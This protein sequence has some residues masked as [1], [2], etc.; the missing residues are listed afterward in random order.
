MDILTE[1]GERNAA[2]EKLASLRKRRQSLLMK[3]EKLKNERVDLSTERPTDLN[4][5]VQKYSDI[6]HTYNLIGV[7]VQSVEPA[8][9]LQFYPLC[10]NQFPSTEFY[11]VH[12]IVKGDNFTLGKHNLPPFIPVERVLDTAKS[13]S[14]VIQQI[15][16]YLYAL[17]QRKG[18]LKLVQEKFESNLLKDIEVD[19]GVTYVRL[20]LAGGE[21][22]PD[23]EITLT[24]DLLKCIPDT[25]D[26][27]PCKEDEEINKKH[28]NQFVK[29]CE[30]LLLSCDVHTAINKIIPKIT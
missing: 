27:K 10:Q 8:L 4:T 16:Q 19:L 29:Q 15:Q 12:L 7:N 11:T 6:L 20:Q 9:I 28:W 1:L 5:E 24:F 23:T 13:S 3:L 14:E 30:K 2:E 18:N 25:V 26:I 17:V 21:N 22:I